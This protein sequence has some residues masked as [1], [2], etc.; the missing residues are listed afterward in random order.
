MTLHRQK[1]A[2]YVACI[3]GREV[4]PPAAAWMWHSMKWKESQNSKEKAEDKGLAIGS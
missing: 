2:G 4:S 1:M 3:G